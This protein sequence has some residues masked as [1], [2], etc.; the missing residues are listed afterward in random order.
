MRPRG[1]LYGR[2][3]FEAVASRRG[4]YGSSPARARLERPGNPV[5]TPLGRGDPAPGGGTVGPMPET[6]PAI[7]GQLADYRA[8]RHALED[9]VLPL[10][11]SVDG[12]RFT[13]QAPL[14]DLR[15]QP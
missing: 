15:L 3:A 8:L 9:A 13:F 12:R 4:R 1:C 5:I 11:T 2:A 14:H 10:G 7:A 6:F